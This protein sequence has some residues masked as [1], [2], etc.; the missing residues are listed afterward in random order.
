MKAANS[1][2]DINK[3]RT[4]YHII[5]GLLVV[6]L[7]YINYPGKQFVIIV[8]SIS[9]G[10]LLLID[11]LRTFTHL[12]SE[13]FRK[14][15]EFLYEDKDMRGP[16]M[17]FFYALSILFSVIIF[18]PEIAMAAIICLSMGDPAAKIGG[19]FLGRTK[20]GNKTLE[21]ALANLV[22]SFIII[23]LIIPN[24]PVSFAGALSGTAIELFSL[25]KID[26]NL[27]IPLLS[28]LVM[29]LTGYFFY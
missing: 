24:T 18:S 28:G 1:K 17:S 23:R 6:I 8:L 14:H 27:S 15:L 2:K 11:L 4:L 12:G 22:V 20:I 19:T 25:P 10:V 29:T 26:D 9:T 16:N 13:L 7:L 5:S 3:A 21:G